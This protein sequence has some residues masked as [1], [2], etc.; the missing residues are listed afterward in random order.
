VGRND[1][2]PLEGDSNQA[3]KAVIPGAVR[4]GGTNRSRGAGAYPMG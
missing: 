3:P 1:T 2:N 4:E